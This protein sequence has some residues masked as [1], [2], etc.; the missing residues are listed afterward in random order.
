MVQEHVLGDLQLLVLVVEDLPVE[1]V[2]DHVELIFRDVHEVGQGL[3]D[4]GVQH[5]QEGQ[6]QEGPKTAGRGLHALLLIEL[7]QLLAVFFPVAGV[8]LGQDLLLFRQSAHSQHT[9]TTFQ[10]DGGQ[11]QTDHQAE[12]DDGHTIAAGDVVE[13]QKQLGK[14]GQ[15]ITHCSASK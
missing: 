6:G 2:G 14:G 3:P 7:G 9:L 12:Q 10:E 15:N 1:Q 8:L 5:H 13:Q 4:D 11:D